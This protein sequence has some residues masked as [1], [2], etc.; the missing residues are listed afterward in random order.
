MKKCCTCE[1]KSHRESTQ[2]LRTIVS[3][4]GKPNEKKK[5]KRARGEKKEE[6]EEGRRQDRRT[7]HEERESYKQIEKKAVQQRVTTPFTDTQ[8]II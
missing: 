1:A 8:R 6:E 4:K 5:R 2:R 3:L 7:I